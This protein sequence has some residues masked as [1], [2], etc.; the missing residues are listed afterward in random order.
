M[1]RLTKLN[2]EVPSIQQH[3]ASLVLVEPA[4]LDLAS[5]WGGLWGPGCTRVDT[6]V[7][8]VRGRSLFWGT[9]LSCRLPSCGQGIHTGPPGVLGGFLRLQWKQLAEP[10]APCL[11]LLV[12]VVCISLPEN[13]VTGLSC[14]TPG[15]ECPRTRLGPPGE[16]RAAW[17]GEGGGAGEEG[18]GCSHSACAGVPFRPILFPF[19]DGLPAPQ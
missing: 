11:K 2:I 17:A 13:L 6:P 9:R 12:T 4:C 18:A 7:P 16:L 19:S 8:S 15:F 1:H 5:L 3:K 14:C 10:A